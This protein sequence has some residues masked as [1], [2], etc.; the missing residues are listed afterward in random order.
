MQA[1][2]RDIAHEGD[3]LV[4]EATSP[5]VLP[6]VVAPSAFAGKVRASKGQLKINVGPG[7][8]LLDGYVNVDVRELPGIDIVS[9]PGALPFAYSSLE[10]VASSH[11]AEHFREHEFKM[12]ILPHWFDL[13]KPGGVIRVIAPNWEAMLQQLEAGGMSIHRFKVLTF[14]GQE[15]EGNDHFAMYTPDTLGDLLSSTGFTDVQVLAYDRDNAGCPE[16]EIVARK[17]TEV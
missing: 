14:G 7:H 15:Y 8:R 13:I 17:P 12:R 16:M 5:R 1:E 6:R 2:V 11:L 3:H 9:G 4:D 10:E